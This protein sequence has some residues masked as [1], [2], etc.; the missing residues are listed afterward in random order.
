MSSSIDNESYP[1][2]VDC[3]LHASDTELLR[4]WR[5]VSHYHRELADA[6]LFAHVHVYESA[7]SSAQWRLCARGVRWPFWTWART[8]PEPL[9][10]LLP[11]P[12]RHT[13]VLDLSWQGARILEFEMTTK[14]IPEEL[15]R[16]FKPH[17]VRLVANRGIY[18][19]FNYIWPE[20]RLIA[21]AD[22]STTRRRAGLDDRIP[23]PR[24]KTVLHLKYDSRRD[25]FF[26]MLA[27]GYTFP[28][29]KPTHDI[30]LIISPD[31]PGPESLID[32]RQTVVQC[33]KRIGYWIRY[34]NEKEWAGD[35]VWDS[36]YRI[37]IVVDGLG[38]LEELAAEPRAT[39]LRAVM[40]NDGANRVPPMSV[41]F[42][43]HAEYRDQIGSEEWA[44]HYD[45]PRQPRG[46]SGLSA[47]LHGWR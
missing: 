42:K 41:T 17:T 29:W 13:R 44:L 11:S 45:W 12:L 23:G 6:H 9:P 4:T 39:A 25:S 40:E 30:T 5:A 35:G 16:A 43:T 18:P 7:P 21:F 33:L 19:R 27:I 2:I 15:L 34:G 3:I 1:D 47:S 20:T 36:E 37:T 46:S 26:R 32:R 31:R 38:Y 22:V 14:P 10:D 24:R 8:D 28:T